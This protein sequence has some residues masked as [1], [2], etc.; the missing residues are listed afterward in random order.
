MSNLINVI[1]RGIRAFWEMSLS[2]PMPWRASLVIV[3]IILFSYYGGWRLLSWLIEK[4]GFVLLAV[5]ESIVSLI[6]LPEYLL[7]R[8]L[9]QHD[10]RPW[11]GTYVFGDILQAVV[12][13]VH[14]WIEKS[15]EV[16]DQWRLRKVWAIVLLI[17]SIPVLLWY[18]RL[19]LE[20]TTIAARYIDQ[21]MA[22]WG[23][24]ERQVLSFE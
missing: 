11:P 17:V 19:G 8:W 24:L 20:D 4:L 10:R 2:V 23:S 5:V 1:K 21:A 7:T 18:V 14:N 3:V 12:I 22:W 6:L 16:R 9:R 13:F 15:A